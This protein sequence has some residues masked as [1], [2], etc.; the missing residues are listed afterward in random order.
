MT[1]V[2]SK[3][4]I[5]TPRA[6]ECKWCCLMNVLG[7]A[8]PCSKT[9]EYEID[10]CFKNQVS[11]NAL[12]RARRPRGHVAILHEGPKSARHH[13]IADDLTRHKIA[14]PETASA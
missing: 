9:T 10:R 13:E 5:S 14:E 1:D 6:C 2:C 11:K 7:K 3:Q 4:G 8:P 12:Q